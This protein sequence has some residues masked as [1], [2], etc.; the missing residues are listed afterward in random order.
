MIQELLTMHPDGMTLREPADNGKSDAAV[1]MEFY[2]PLNRTC[3]QKF[4]SGVRA[5]V[6]G[7]RETPES[8]HAERERGVEK[9]LF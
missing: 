7:R 1:C 6:Q 3:S 8:Q 5:S 4:S 2:D 9:D